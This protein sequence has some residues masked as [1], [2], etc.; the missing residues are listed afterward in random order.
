MP[1]PAVA[2]A[3]E[4]FDDIAIPPTL[5][6]LL[7]ARDELLQGMKQLPLGDASSGNVFA[8][9]I[10]VLDDLIVEQIRGARS[11]PDRLRLVSL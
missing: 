2:N 3:L 9:T 10:E 6:A 5:D 7:R 4:A 1:N 11:G 8:H